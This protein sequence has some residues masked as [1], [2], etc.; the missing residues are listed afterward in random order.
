MKQKF[1]VGKFVLIPSWIFPIEIS[2]KY[3]PKT[4]LWDD[5]K[6]SPCP[7]GVRDLQTERCYYGMG[8]NRCQWFVRYDWEE[9]A[10]CIA[11][12]HPEESKQSE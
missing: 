3:N 4:K 5:V 7:F 12:T 6:Y 2:R 11:C 1:Y 9:H 10:G 8:K